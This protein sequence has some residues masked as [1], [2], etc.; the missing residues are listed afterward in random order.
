MIKMHAVVGVVLAMFA[1]PSK[2]QVPSVPVS[3][4]WVGALDVVHADGSVEADSAYFSLEQ[5]GTTI[6][7]TAGNSPADKTP[8]ASGEIS[9]NRVTLR[10]VVNPQLTV[11]FDLTMEGDHLRGSATGIPSEAGSHIVVAA[12]RA[13]KE[14]HSTEPVTH[15]PD[16]L[17]ATVAA[18]DQK[19]FEAYNKCDLTTLGSMVSED[20]EFYHDKTGLEVGRQAFVESIQKNICGKTQRVLVP[21][22]LEVHRLATFGAMEMG[23]HRFTHPGHEEWGVGEAKFIQLWQL[24]DSEWK[25]VRVISYDHGTASK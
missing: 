22:T 2:G 19:L 11:A 16:T 25:L 13:D 5:S 18:L 10:V 3:G 8:I 14:W 6:T 12:V 24:K 7:G 4:N 20:L 21:G 9:G 15:V 23:T 1:V 17:Y